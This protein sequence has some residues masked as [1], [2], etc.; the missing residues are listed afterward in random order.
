VE[1]CAQVG[2]ACGSCWSPRYIQHR[3]LC[4]IWRGTPRKHLLL[5]LLLLPLLLLLLLLLLV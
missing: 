4:P 1:W 5:L 3:L 2:P